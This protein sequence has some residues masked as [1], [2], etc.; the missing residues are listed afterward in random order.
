[1]YMNN[2]LLKTEL[3][4]LLNS[5]NATMENLQKSYDIFV[6]KLNSMISKNDDIKT[7]F[8]LFS[9]AKI[10]IEYLLQVEKKTLI[11]S[12]LQKHYQC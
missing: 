9:H 7:N 5:E 12:L 8:F 11:F 2:K 4:S 3:I 6:N 1:M 10:E